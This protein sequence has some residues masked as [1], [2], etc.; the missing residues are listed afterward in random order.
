ML[1]WREWMNRVFRGLA[2]AFTLC[3]LFAA[4]GRAQFGRLIGD[5]WIVK[6]G[7]LLPQS[8]EAKDVGKYWFTGGLEYNIT[9]QDADRVISAE[10]LY[11]TRSSDITS[12]NLTY[13]TGLT[14]WS[15]GA[16]YKIR[17]PGLS[18]TDT[19]LFY[20][21]GAGIYNTKVEVTHPTDESLSI[22]EDKTIPGVH[23]FIGY[24]M[25]ENLQ[26]EG[27]YT[28]LFGDNNDVKFNG[29][30]LLAGLKF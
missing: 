23:V 30:M 20:G 25:Y 16:N 29:F 5:Q 26:L 19:V 24:E 4:P 14:M 3:A 2:A 11:T 7:V 8:S 9:P 10:V 18:A 1:K 21:A 6:A 27:R 12:D 22:D 15:V 28:Y 13:D 17:K